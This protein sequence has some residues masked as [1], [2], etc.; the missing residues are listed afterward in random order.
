MSSMNRS[1]VFWPNRTS[2]ALTII[3]LAPSY[4]AYFTPICGKSSNPL[5]RQK[6]LS[7]NVAKYKSYS[8]YV[9]KQKSV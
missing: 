9:I 8:E 1:T 3:A 2:G 6:Q 7:L 4:A 5:I